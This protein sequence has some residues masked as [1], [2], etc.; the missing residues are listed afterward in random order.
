MQQ[1]RAT[2]IL[3]L[4]AWQLQERTPH[5]KLVRPHTP[6]KSFDN[7]GE[8]P[9]NSMLFVGK[10]SAQEGVDDPACIDGVGTPP[11]DAGC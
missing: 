2:A 10:S 4:A 11:S 9:A 8:A 1:L 5:I 7:L 6:T 3:P